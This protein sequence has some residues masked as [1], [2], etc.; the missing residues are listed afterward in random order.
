MKQVHFENPDVVRRYAQGPTAFVPAYEQMQRMTA[1]LIKEGIGDV[2]ELLV[3]GAGGGFELEVFASLQSQWRYTGVDPAAEMLN[4][5]KARLAAIDAS[6]RVNWHH[7]YITDAPEGPFDAASCLLTLHFVADDG[8]KLQTLLELKKRLKPGAPF[9]LVDCCIDISSPSAEL[10]LARYR[11]FA[12][13]SGADP[14]QVSTTCD[15]LVNVLKMVSPARNEALLKSVGFTDVEL[16]YAGLSW[17]G[18]RA[19]A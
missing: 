9:V 10:M 3:L 17:R 2:G 8:S 11:D 16:F 12:L 5:A 4:A 18:W 7:G 15:R 13:G 6:E 1:Q 14:E 19:T